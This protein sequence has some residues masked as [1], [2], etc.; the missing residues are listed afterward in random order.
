M[1]FKFSVTESGF[2]DIHAHLTYCDKSFVPPLGSR[3]DIDAYALKIFHEADRFE[4]WA[5]DALIGLL[6]VY[7]R[8]SHGGVA[9]VTS[10]SVS[11]GWQGRGVAGTLLEN[12]LDFVETSGL[13]AIDLEVAQHNARAIRFYEKFGFVTVENG[14]EK[15]RMRLNLTE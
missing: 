7:C 9:F 10:I 15:K 2:S 5:S 6:A 8:R 3:V 11:P 14:G 1:D 4:A 13:R 12:C